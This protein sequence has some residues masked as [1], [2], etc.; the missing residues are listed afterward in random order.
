MNKTTTTLLPAYTP[1]QEQLIIYLYQFR[2]LNT[3]QFQKLFNHKDPH[4]IKQWLK[5]LTTKGYL[6]SD[7]KK[8]YF[9]INQLSTH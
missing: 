7:Y 1:K 8:M 5:D 2:F 4:R 6:Q 3:H 9:H